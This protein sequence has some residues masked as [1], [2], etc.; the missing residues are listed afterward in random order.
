MK[1][2]KIICTHCHKIQPREYGAFC[3]YCNQMTN[4]VYDLKQVKFRDSEN[5][6]LRFFD[7]LPVK[8]IELL[9]K[10]ASYTPTIHAKKLG[11]F[12]KMPKL[13]LKNETTL[14]TGSTKF[15]NASVTLAYLY[16][17]GIYHF[18]TSS[19]GNSSSANAHCISDFPEMKMSL[20]TSAD[21]RSRVNYTSNPTN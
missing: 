18:C 6:Y 10:G 14:P 19:T 9:P 8:D 15:R 5:P 3:E 17:N 21:F 4:I 11:A 12:L 13:Y 20:F 7:L 2:L 16:E 1:T